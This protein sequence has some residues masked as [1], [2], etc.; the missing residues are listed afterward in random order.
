MDDSTPEKTSSRQVWAILVI[1]TI[2]EIVASFW[3]VHQGSIAGWDESVYRT[4]AQHISGAAT[5][6][7]SHHRPPL[8]PLLQV[9]F[10]QHFRWIIALAHIACVA[11]GFLILRRTTNIRWA[12][13]GTILIMLSADLRYYNLFMLT[14][15]VT[16][17]FLL[18]LTY[19]LVT[20]R[21]VI[22]G[23]LAALLMLTHWQMIV[24]FPAAVFTLLV[25]SNRRKILP[26][27]AGYIATLLP[28]MAASTWIYGNPIHPLLVSLQLNTS[29]HASTHGIFADNDWTYYLGQLPVAHL[30]LFVTTVLIGARALRKSFAGKRNASPDIYITAVCF[31]VF[32]LV[33]LH[34]ALAKDVRLVVPVVPLAIITILAFVARTCMH[35]RARRVVVFAALAFV[36]SGNVHGANLLWAIHDLK[37]DPAN[38]FTQLPVGDHADTESSTIYTDLNDLAATAHYARPA[39]PVVGRNTRHHRFYDRPTIRRDE[40]P[41]GALYI[42][43]NPQ[44]ASIL[45]TTDTPKGGQLYLV[46]WRQPTTIVDQTSTHASPSM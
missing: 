1:L 7:F 39:I 30:L 21:I 46:R 31:L 23:V 11:F 25:T 10:A 6:S 14:E 4:N 32:L 22:A 43:W 9:I 45:S 12:I 41:D 36:V 3:F 38:A 26:L 35:H 19:M 15:L 8:F 34:L 33:P 16:A 24:I 27:S 13:A 18:A 28:F 2:T 20:H 40:I 17:A 29:G 44:N 5:V 37:T 42:T